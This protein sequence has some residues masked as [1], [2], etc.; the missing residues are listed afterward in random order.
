MTQQAQIN[1]ADI[2]D[3]VKWGVKTIQEAFFI[4][5]DNNYLT[6]NVS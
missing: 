1:T 4:T 5:W 3:Y 2:Q 6:Q